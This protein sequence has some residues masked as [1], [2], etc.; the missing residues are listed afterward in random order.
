MRKSGCIHFWAY[1]FFGEKVVPMDEKNTF[2]GTEP[3]GKLMR[4]EAWHSLL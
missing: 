3:I 1:A 2:L 4:G